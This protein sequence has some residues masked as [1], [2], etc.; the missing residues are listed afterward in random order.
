MRHRFVLALCALTLGA[1]FVPSLA[2]AAGAAG[3]TVVKART[4]SKVTLSNTG[5]AFTTVESL[6]L[7]A[8]SWTVTSDVT[9]VN[10]GAGDFVRCHLQ[11]NGSTID[12]GATTYLANRVAGL[13]NVGTLTVSSDSET[14]AVVCGHDRNVSTQMYVD[15]GATMIAVSGG[16]ISGPGVPATSTTAVAQARSTANTS[17]PKAPATATAVTR[18]LPSG[19]WAITADLTAVDFGGADI[20][21]CELVVS[22]GASVSA[23]FD[24]PGVGAADDT[25]TRV[26]LEGVA[27]MPSGGGSVSVACRSANGTAMYVD[28]GATLTATRTSASAVADHELTQTT[29]SSTGGAQT[30]VGSVDLPAGTWR[31]RSF[32]NLGYLARRDFLR[33]TLMANGASIDGGATVEITPDSETEDVVSSG[34]FTASAKWTLS[35]VCSHDAGDTSTSGHWM[36]FGGDIMAVNTAAK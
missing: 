30:T 23:A 7:D 27:T 17:V 34:T 31:V 11:A 29:L 10:F 14:V 9:A 16:P 5:G 3:A 21:E 4:T 19:T 35:L 28:A 26:D 25:A 33:C 1:W 6:L 22:S 24:Q 18:A 8:G 13:T 15:P 36:T 20:A 2:T 12:G 32:V